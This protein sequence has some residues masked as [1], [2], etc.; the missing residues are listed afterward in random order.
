MRIPVEEDH[1]MKAK[2]MVAAEPWR[3]E[4]KESEIVPR[5]MDQLLLKLNVT[6]VCASDPKIFSGKILWVKF[7]LI[8]G[9]ESVGQVAERG[10]I[11][12]ERGVTFRRMH[13]C[14]KGFAT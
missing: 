6:S 10:Q 1:S 11:A 8:M 3:M 9:H 13:S 4:L 5:L 12:G 14:L 2:A 7:P